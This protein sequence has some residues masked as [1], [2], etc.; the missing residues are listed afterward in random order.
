[1]N[2]DQLKILGIVALVLFLIA[3]FMYSGI[4][5]TGDSFRSGSPLIQGLDTGKI[6][7]LTISSKDNSLTLKKTGD[8]FSL[9]EKNNYPAD[10]SKINELLVDILEVRLKEK[11]SENADY[12]EE[13]GVSDAHDEAVIVSLFDANDEP[14][15][16]LVKGKSLERGSGSYVRQLNGK[17]AY[18]SS[19]YLSINSSINN[20]LETSLFDIEAEKISEVR[21]SSPEGFYQI[22]R[23]S[24]G[25]TEPA[26]EGE[27]AEEESKIVLLNVPAGRTADDTEYEDVFEALVDLE[28]D[29][30]SPAAELTGLNWDSVF[31]CRLDSGL[32][33]RVR[34][35]K[36]EDDKYYVALSAV[37]PLRERI[38]ITQQESEEELK[39]KE[40]LLLANDKTET[41]NALHTG[42][43]YEISSI[44]GETLRKAFDE[45]LEAVE[46][47]SDQK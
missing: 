28:F 19:N 20:Y 30:V 18:S 44:D 12:F 15:T 23:E 37:S 32:L 4:T 46:E 33:Y 45:L 24:N 29:D 41:F 16:G 47:E 42:W 2:Q 39:K 1:M 34:S 9:V 25:E 27:E 35:A 17:I 8:S 10:I 26:A 21:V 38:Q 7:K 6:A 22:V 40:T 14:L 43:V 11:I 3:G 13:L 5:F 36:A 31:E